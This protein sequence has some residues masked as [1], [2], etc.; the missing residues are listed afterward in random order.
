MCELD[1]ARNP[2]RRLRP[3]GLKGGSAGKGGLQLCLNDHYEECEDK[4][5][6][7]IN[8]L[9]DVVPELTSPCREAAL[10]CAVFGTFGKI[11]NCTK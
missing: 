5:Y 4:T 8:A 6:K 3:K 9:I 10:R 2:R 1:V 7:H 11:Y